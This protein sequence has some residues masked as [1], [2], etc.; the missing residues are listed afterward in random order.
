M[1]YLGGTRDGVFTK[2]AI[3]D[4]EY[5]IA[6]KDGKVFHNL[7]QMVEVSDTKGFQPNSSSLGIGGILICQ[8]G[9]TFRP[10]W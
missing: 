10:G 8:I 7:H 6:T 3:P 1:A 5:R 9:I 4:G 2:G